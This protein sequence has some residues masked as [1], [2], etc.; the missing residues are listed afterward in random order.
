MKSIVVGADGPIGRALVQALQHRD[1]FVYGTTRR[2][3]NLSANNL[4]LDLSDQHVADGPLP[5]VDIAFFCAAISSFSECRRDPTLAHRVNVDS[6]AALARRLVTSGARVVLLSTNAVFDGKMP[7]VPASS[8]TCPVSVYGRV[9]AEAEAKFLTLG[10]AAAILRLSKVLTPELKLLIGWIDALSRGQQ[11]V[12][13]T[14]LRIAPVSLADAVTALLAI[15]DDPGG[16]I[17]QFSSTRDIS[18]AE[19][20]RHLAHRIGVSSDHVMERRA[21][22]AGIPVEEIRCFSSLDS[23]RLARIMRRAAPD[24]FAVLD[25]VYGPKIEA[26]VA[27]NRTMR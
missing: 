12:A 16:G 23:S 14:D 26:L 18:Y 11:I 9:K 24:P 7:I 6:P 22:D 25:A 27:K 5:S 1:G 3:S 2:P 10:S 21:V 15:P 4:Y 8:R 13:F 19:V 17:Y 20:A